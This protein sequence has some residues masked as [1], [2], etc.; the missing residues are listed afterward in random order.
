MSPRTHHHVC[1]VQ[2]AS[3]VL[4]TT[5]SEDIA[6]AL[7]ALMRPLGLL[8]VPVKQV[9]VRFGA[10]V[11]CLQVLCVHHS[12]GCLLAVPLLACGNP[13]FH[14]LGRSCPRLWGQLLL[15]LSRR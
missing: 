7:Q 15:P 4:T 11:P 8:G 5:P 10:L 13:L 2:T 9:G 12:S 6:L 1:G 14:S 3:L